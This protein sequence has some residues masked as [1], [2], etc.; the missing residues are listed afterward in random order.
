M[1]IKD[2]PARAFV[3]KSVDPTWPKWAYTPP[4]DATQWL[5]TE[6]EAQRLA[7]AYNARHAHKREVT[8]N[9]EQKLF[10]IPSGDSGFSCFG[11]D[12]CYWDSVQ[13]AHLLGPSG[14]PPTETGTLK[15]YAHYRKL[16][17]QYAA[18][19]DLNKHTW[20][21]PGTPPQ[22]R[23]I[24]EDARKSNRRLRLFQGDV[25]TGK[26]WLE[27][28]DVVGTIGRSTGPQRVPLLIRSP[29]STGGGAILTDCV[30]AILSVETRQV[31][32]RH[33][34]FEF[35]TFEL[36]TGDGAEPGLTFEAWHNGEVV[37]RFK[38]A[39][40]RAAYIAFHQGRRFS[41]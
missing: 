30:V 34:G 18:R 33:P 4:S 22:V 25:V 9:A 7:D 19:P 14:E 20:F 31:L 11:F 16:C 5:D 12:N 32:Y 24:L 13:L 35:P 15:A 23:G 1:K 3:S 17:A 29:R 38:T 8:V 28:H 40:K 26:P 37:A 6:E 10:V 27:E 2:K 41:L 36:R 39:E 21:T